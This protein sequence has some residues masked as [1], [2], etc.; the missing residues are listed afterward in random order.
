M[1]IV[2]LYNGLLDNL[3]FLLTVAA[4]PHGKRSSSWNI[5][6]E[7]RTA[8]VSMHSS[9]LLML[10]LCLWGLKVDKIQDSPVAILPES[11]YPLGYCLGVTM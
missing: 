9:S 3:V 2:A 1:S 10:A 8:R 7:R 6:H 5:E 11:T 4:L